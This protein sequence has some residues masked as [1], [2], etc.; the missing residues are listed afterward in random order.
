ML[1]LDQHPLCLVIA[2]VLSETPQDT[3]VLLGRSETF[4]LNVLSCLLLRSAW[5]C[6]TYFHS[7]LLMPQP[8]HSKWLPTMRFISSPSRAIC[9][10]ALSSV[11][12]ESS[13]NPDVWVR[14]HRRSFG[15]IYEGIRTQRAKQMCWKPTTV[16]SHV[17]AEIIAAD[18]CKSWATGNRIDSSRVSQ[19][20]IVQNSVFSGAEIH[21][22]LPSCCIFKHIWRS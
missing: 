11:S 22:I 21:V 6:T 7:S 15:R 3:G 2:I 20:M 17:P 13:L 19:R 16:S 4:S 8:G 14:S 10:S 12:L 5:Y 1:V 9:Y 18:L